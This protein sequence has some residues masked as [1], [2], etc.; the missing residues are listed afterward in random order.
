MRGRRQIA[1][2]TMIAATLVAVGSWAST[3]RDRPYLPAGELRISS[4]LPSGVYDAFVTM[5]ASRVRQRDP[6]L[7]VQV[8]TSTGSIQNLRR[9][10][11]GSADCTV[12]AADAAASAVAGRAPEF[13]HPVALVAIARIYDDYVQL[14][15]RPGSGIRSVA[16][17]RGKRVS[18]GAA[19]SGV[20]LIAGR[21]LAAAGL[22]QHE[23][24][25]RS[26]GLSDSL[27]A[28]QASTLDAAFWSGGLPTAAVAAR[29]R[30]GSVRLV[31]LSPALVTALTS[32][33]PDAYR[34]A[35]VAVAPYALDAPV[36]TVATPNFVVCRPSIDPALA[37]LL[38]DTIFA[39]QSAIARQLPA[40]NTVD[41]RS[42]I[43]TGPIPLDDGAV[44]WYRRQ[45]P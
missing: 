20:E 14:I 5:L 27:A 35:T 43:S 11:T 24:Q 22:G 16:D 37:E 17:L 28:L 32:R 34:A 45:K 25:S 15:A 18:L 10:D 6:L 36:P 1:V 13:S 7:R 30:S 26:I 39:S 23:L 31:P 40:A 2:V 12:T 33:Y 41:L 29:I 42:A 8:L 44:M 21:V 3:T 9:V 19:G 38:T 4:G